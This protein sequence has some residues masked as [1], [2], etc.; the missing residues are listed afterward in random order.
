MLCLYEQ[1]ILATTAP[2][3]SVTAVMNSAIFC[4]AAPKD[5]SLRNTKPPGQ[6]SFHA[7]IQPHLKGQITIHPLWEDMGDISADHSHTTIPILDDRS[8]SSYRRH[9]SHSQCSCHSGPHH[10]LTSGCLHHHSCHDTS[11]RN[12]HTSS[13]TCHFSH[14]HHSCHYSMDHS[15]SCSISSHCTAWGPQPMKKV[16]PHPRASTSHKSHCYIIHDSTS[17]SSSDSDDSDSLNY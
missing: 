6:A 4:K 1:V 9:T 15:L 10:P 17:D 14:Q 2:M 5:H 16:K 8:S 13:Q 7:T 3:H 11:H 12:S